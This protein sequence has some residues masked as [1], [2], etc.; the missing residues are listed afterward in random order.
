MIHLLKRILIRISEIPTRGLPNF[1]APKVGDGCD[2]TLI[3]TNPS[4]PNF[5]YGVKYAG[6]EPILV[7][8]SLEVLGIDHSQWSFIDI[9]C[10]KG[11]VLLRAERY[12]FKAI[13]GVEYSE[14]LAAVAKSL[15]KRSLVIVSDAMDFTFPEGPKVIFMY[16]PFEKKL[17]DQFISKLRGEI[18]LIYIGIGRNWA[19]EYE[20]FKEFC[21]TK[22][23]VIYHMQ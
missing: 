17:F 20:R 7:N 10:G 16:H 15:V 11:R 23:V 14:Q 21:R 1:R 12:P 4:S 13:I 6:C 8:Y 19:G 2:G 22:D 5:K 18:I 3:L 9:G